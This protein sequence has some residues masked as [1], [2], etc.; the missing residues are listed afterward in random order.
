M[1]KGASISKPHQGWIHITITGEPFER[2]FQH[3]YL[4]ANQFKHIRTVLTFI[5]KNTFGIS[6]TEYIQTCVEL[7]T[8]NI[9]KYHPEC[10]EEIRGIS[11]GAKVSVDF[12]IAWNS[13]LSMYSYY[14]NLDSQRCSA[15]IACGSATKDGKIV[16]A[17]NTH[18]DYA[19]GSLANIVMRIVP[20]KGHSFVMQTYAGYIAS[21]TDWFLCDTGIIGCETTIS[22][23]NYEIKFG[24]PYFCRIRE[25]MQYGESLEEY[26]EIMLKNNAGDYACSWLF[27]DINRNKIMLCEIGLNISNIQTTTDGVF[28]GM[29][30]AM[31]FE[32]RTLE[33]SDRSFNDLGD[34]S[35]ARNARLNALLNDKYYGKIDVEV[36]K[37]VISDHYDTKL[38]RL[39][40]S[41]LTVCKHTDLDPA[42]GA[43]HPFYPWGC[44]D[45]KV[46]DSSM[47]K[48]MEF[49]GRQGAACGISFVAKKYL[50]AHPEYAKWKPVLR[51]MP[52]Y[53]W[54]KL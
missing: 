33:T 39:I 11:K 20:A 1:L 18:S 30:S 8:P 9:A 46:T 51:D 15:F 16:M 13:L 43:K 50:K 35:G 6:L 54:T 49:V 24:T 44:V 2:G 29:N 36:A 12:L 25:A 31:D 3:G 27:G 34:S 23:T 10:L 21:A 53:K 52:T 5:V 22:D 17:H 14:E 19:S 42:P 48:R 32:L 45:G 37:R 47:A 4:L 28:Y 26:A 40:P 7:I 41:S 38:N